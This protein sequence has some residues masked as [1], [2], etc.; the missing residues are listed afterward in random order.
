MQYDD[1]RS[2]TLKSQFL[3]LQTFSVAINPA[4]IDTSN[5]ISYT[6]S[7][8]LLLTNTRMWANAQ[9][10]GRPAEYRWRPL[11]NAVVWLTPTTG[12]PCSNAA[13]MR[14]ALK[15]PGVPQT[16]ETISAASR[17]KFT[18]LWGHLEEMLLLNKFF[19]D[20]RYVP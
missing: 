11:L 16:N 1:I 3:W 20:C 15:L 19:S 13:K 7:Y 6:H 18:I 14:N 4:A 17:P 12:V 9:R 10:D 8:V 5:S 2:D